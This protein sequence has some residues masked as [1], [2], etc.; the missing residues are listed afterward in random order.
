[1]T[2][3]H[4]S[5]GVRASAVKVRAGTATRASG[6]KQVG[7]SS[8][9]IHSSY[10]VK[11]DIPYNDIAIWKLSSTIS[12]ISGLTTETGTRVVSALRTATVS[13][14]SRANCHSQYG[15]LSISDAMWCAGVTAG[16]EYA[17]S[18]D[19]GG[20]IVNSSGTLL[21]VVSWGNG[22]ARKGN[23][24]VYTRA[25]SFVDWINTIRLRLPFRDYDG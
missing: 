14:I 12:E 15:T 5:E 22:C 19:S 18:G 16:G 20:P 21:G 6:G 23:A 9:K 4:C 7:F 17:C 13:V 11:D 1:M 10:T 8:I 24:G 2:A 3:G 25:S